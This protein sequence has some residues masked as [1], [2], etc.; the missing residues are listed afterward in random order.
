MGFVQKT[1]S[2]FCVI[3]SY[4]SIIFYKNNDK[5]VNQPSKNRS[6]KKTIKLIIFNKIKKESNL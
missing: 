2:F 6:E 4:N 5:R 1:L 3:W